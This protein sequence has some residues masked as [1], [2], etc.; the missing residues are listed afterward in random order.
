VP[1]EMLREMPQAVPGMP[2]DPGQDFERSVSCFQERG[3]IREKGRHLINKLPRKTR[4]LL[5]GMGCHDCKHGRNIE[6]DRDKRPVPCGAFC[7]R[8]LDMLAANC[9]AC[10]KQVP[11]DGLGRPGVC[12]CADVLVVTNGPQDWM[13]P[14]TGDFALL[15]S[16]SKQLMALACKHC[17]N[18]ENIIRGHKSFL[19]VFCGSCRARISKLVKCS[20]RECRG[21]PY[22]DARGHYPEYCNA[23]N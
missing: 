18:G 3:P 12:G 21:R 19:Q 11:T 7:L 16:Y 1:Q 4:A 2:E 13:A 9:E 8:C 17:K 22:V 23:C 15:P 14:E 5:S 6:L 10:G 20:T